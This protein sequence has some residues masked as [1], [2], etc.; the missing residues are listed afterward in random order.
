MQIDYRNLR[1]SNLMHTVILL[2]CWCVFL[3]SGTYIATQVQCL[4]TSLMHAVFNSRMSIVL[5]A[6][7]SLLPFLC[8]AV[9]FRLGRFFL[10]IPVVCIKAFLFGF[11]CCLI[12]L[13]FGDAGWLMRWLLV[14]TDSFLVIPLLCYWFKNTLKP[15]CDAYQGVGAYIILVLVLLCLEF[16]CIKPILSKLTEC[17][18]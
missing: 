1:N 6:C 11:S 8:S 10:L 9:A 16:Y 4:N 17:T 18:M 7:V 3:I 12:N 15:S 5:F 14:F 2:A 13:L